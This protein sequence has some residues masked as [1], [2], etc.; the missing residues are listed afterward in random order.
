[1]NVLTGPNTTSVT[2]AP[3]YFLVTDEDGNILASTP[4]IIKLY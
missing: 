1:V 4:A 3:S 2:L